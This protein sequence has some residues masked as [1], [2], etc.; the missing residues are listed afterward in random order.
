MNRRGFLFTALGAPAVVVG[1][2]APT[3]RLQPPGLPV[4]PQ[5]DFVDGA[6]YCAGLYYGRRV[7]FASP[8]YPNRLWFSRADPPRRFHDPYGIGDWVDVGDSWDRIVSV[9]VW[10][11]DL[12]IRKLNSEWQFCGDLDWGIFYFLGDPQRRGVLRV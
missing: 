1:A 11:A 10:H 3:T 6:H 12:I 5:F 4:D 9:Y 8:N 2:T 7:A